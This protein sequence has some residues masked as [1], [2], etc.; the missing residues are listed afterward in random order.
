MALYVVVVLLYRLRLAV[1]NCFG[2]FC[3]LCCEFSCS[4]LGCVW[5]V[6]VSVWAGGRRKEGEV[7]F[8]VLFADSLVEAEG[9]Y[10][11]HVSVVGVRKGHLCCMHSCR[12]H[13]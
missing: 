7:W 4:C 13:G 8:F 5:L 11:R 2:M 10:L 9:C 6:L 3:F 1:V 12:L